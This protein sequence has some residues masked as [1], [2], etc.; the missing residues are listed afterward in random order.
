MYIL[1]RIRD[2]CR[3]RVL[4]SVVYMGMKPSTNVHNYHDVRMID[5]EGGG[6]TTSTPDISR[7]NDEQNI[8]AWSA[9][10]GVK[11]LCAL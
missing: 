6:Y 1:D 4:V 3:M 2:S 11:T 7:I 10:N 8:L 9:G 5:N